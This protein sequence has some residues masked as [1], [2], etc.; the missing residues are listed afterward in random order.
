M[1]SFKTSDDLE[2]AYQ[3]WGEGSPDAVPVV[4][5]HGFVADANANWVLP[6]VV[7][8]LVDRGRRVIA[9][10]A[11]GHGA[12]AKPHDP[13]RY[14][15]PVMA[16]DLAELIDVIGVGQI[17]LVGYSM[18]A[19]VALLLASTDA[20]VRRLVIGGVGAGVVECGGVD[21]RAVSNESI[22][23]A[24]SVE[25]AATLEQPEARS[26]RA[27]ADALGADRKALVAQASSVHRRG[28][29]LERVA[30]P[31]LII[32]GADDPLA[33]RPEALAAALPD[34]TV[35][36][37]AGDHMGALADPAFTRSL[38]D[39]LCPAAVGADAGDAG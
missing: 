27:L 1:N 23:Q 14:G 20:R 10:D 6:G 24:L 19:I 4:L 3:E 34:A 37:T 35:T 12:S 9:P 16:R 26:Y 28:V 32:A 11:R 36:L 22:I 7:A 29:A 15:E 25:D 2:I 38:V 8:A 30:A 21:R 31:T 17:D 39:F 33:V 18:G 5:H 13:T